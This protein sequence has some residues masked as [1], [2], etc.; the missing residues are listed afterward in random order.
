MG[1]IK[2]HFVY[3]LIAATIAGS[4]SR[5]G[6][7]QLFNRGKTNSHGQY[8]PK[9]DNYKL[10]NKKGFVKPEWLSTNAVYKLTNPA[11]LAEK[12]QKNTAQT[13][14][15]YIKF[16][17]EG[18]CLSIY[19][20]YINQLTET[21]LNP[22]NPYCSKDY[23]YSA[24]GETIQFESFVY[25]E[26]YGKFVILN[27]TPASKGDSLILQQKKLQLIYKKEPLPNGWQTYPANW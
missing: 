12:T 9:K 22:N 17:P 21:D 23:Y 3:L 25:G 1:R 8:V 13:K 16:Y 4:C 26:G 20:P 14:R 15:H 7:D 2:L 18:R 6:T 27:Y 10:K 24:D 5:Q 19:I 11:V